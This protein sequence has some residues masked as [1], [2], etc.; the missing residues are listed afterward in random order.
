M[1]VNGKW[2]GIAIADGG[3]EGLVSMPVTFALSQTGEKLSGNAESNAKTYPILNG[4]VAGHQI[5]F[6]IGSDDEYTRFELTC[7][8]ERISGRAITNRR[9]RVT[10]NGALSLSR[11]RQG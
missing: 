6:E 4:T 8:R 3:P 10:L 5:H 1:Q 9:H 11:V 2:S 7:D